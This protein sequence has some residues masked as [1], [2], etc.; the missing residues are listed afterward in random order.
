MN[1][2]SR[3]AALAVTFLAVPAALAAQ[4]RQM[5][6]RPPSPS[7]TAEAAARTWFNELQR[8]S[9]RLQAAHNRAMQDAQL[10]TA[11]E[12]F[13]RDVKAAMQRQ[14][15]G[16][17]ALAGRVRQIQAEGAA[18]QQR[19]DRVRLRELNRELSQ[20]Q[21]RFMAAQQ[22]VM[23]Q[24]AIAQRARV[25]EEQLHSRMVQVEPETDRLIE[26]GKD[27]QLRL[28]RATGRAPQGALPGQPTS[29]PPQ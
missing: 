13:M 10:R 6:T 28:M 15:P 25:L 16:L 2:L 19:G 14:D 7:A 29:R 12:A 23:R 22:A 27:L 17:D 20:I 26:R 8:I 5:S 24:P 9:A 4:Q 21:A 18:A 3:A 1:R 11:Q